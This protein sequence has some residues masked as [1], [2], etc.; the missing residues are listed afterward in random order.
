M[1]ESF[2]ARLKES[3]RKDLGLGPKARRQEAG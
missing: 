3:A 2:S 1:A